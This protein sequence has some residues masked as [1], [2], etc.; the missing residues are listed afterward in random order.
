MVNILYQYID[1]KVG[2]R[3]SLGTNNNDADDDGEEAILTP[4]SRRR[5]EKRRS[6]R[7]H[8]D[9]SSASFGNRVKREAIGQSEL[10]ESTG[11]TASLSEE[12]VQKW[13][14]RLMRSNSLYSKVSCSFFGNFLLVSF[15][16]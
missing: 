11:T 2:Y 14:L 15:F 3:T 9:F 13:A 16:F 5:Q 7:P 4:V 6:Q 1:Q 12:Q 8:F 10:E